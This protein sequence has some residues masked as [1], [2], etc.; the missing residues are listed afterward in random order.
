LKVFEIRILR[1]KFGPKRD[2]WCEGGENCIAKSLINSFF[3]KYKQ[4]NQVKADEIGSACSTHKN[5]NS[6]RVF[7]G[8]T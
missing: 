5:T 2:E 6:R 7:V 4:K 3:T 1:R 8:K